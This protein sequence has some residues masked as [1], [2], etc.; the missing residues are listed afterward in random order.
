MFENL[1]SEIKK[2]HKTSLT[3]IGIDG[4]GGVG[5]TTLATNILKEL[6][7]VQI[8]HM[9]DFDVKKERKMSNLS[10]NRPIG[11]DTQWFRVLQEV[12]LPLKSREK[13]KFIRYDRSNDVYT[14]EVIVKPVGIVLI[15]GVFAIRRELF[16]HFDFSVWV[17]CSLKT[18]VKRAL[19]RD[20]E[21]ARALWEKDWLP[22]EDKY[23]KVY[24]PKSYAHFIYETE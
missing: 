23:M 2:H 9:D 10:Q 11:P 17:E 19:A 24:D 14:D 1:L 8:V 18:R 3:M 15:E 22:M 20:G 7:D 21:I 12:I 6:L 5:K 16:S 4:P 13:A